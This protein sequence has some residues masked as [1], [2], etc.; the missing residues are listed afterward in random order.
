MAEDPAITPS[1]R[2]VLG[3]SSPHSPSSSSPKP[4]STPML[5]DFSRLNTSSLAYPLDDK[6][7]SL[8]NFSRI[9]TTLTPSVH[10]TPSNFSASFPGLSI[11]SV[12]GRSSPCSTSS[13]DIPTPVAE[14]RDALRRKL[15]TTLT[16]SIID[17]EVDDSGYTDIDDPPSVTPHTT[18]PSSLEPDPSPITDLPQLKNPAFEVL[19][20]FKAASPPI[21]PQLQAVLSYQF[22]K[23][24]PITTV[25]DELRSTS[26]QHE[27]LTQLLIPDRA[28][29]AALAERSPNVTNQGIHVFLDMS[30]INISFQDMLRSRYQLAENARFVPLPQLNLPFLT[31]ILVRGRDA[32]ILNAGCSVQPGRSV[33]H[34]VRQLRDLD[35]RVD[36]RERKR[37]EEPA[38]TPKKGPYANFSSSDEAPSRKQV[39]YVEDLVDETL[40]TRIAESVMEHFSRPGTLVMATGDAKP[41][42]YSDGFFT[43]A[44][45]ALKMGWHVEVVSWR[46]SLSNSWRNPEWTA[47]WG[48]KFR[49]IELDDYIDDLLSVP[50]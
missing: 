29:D 27:S 3:V 31:E 20:T 49:V 1:P 39:R 18:P 46:S 45:R 9:F 38:P 50:N 32:N 13:R 30:N 28:I 26:Q 44:D 37:S 19:P 15:F 17:S 22:F 40:Q 4:V 7:A 34:F 2:T 36:L 21:Q 43:Y 42:K 41:A 10:A 14:I 6:P 5:G 35:Y 16:P 11:S 25:Y 8:G 12:D 48:D 24:G 33:P 23:H 47:Q